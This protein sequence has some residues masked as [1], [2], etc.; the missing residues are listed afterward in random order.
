[1]KSVSV[2]A[3]GLW[4]DAKSGEF[5]PAAAREQ[6][7]R[8][9]EDRSTLVAAIND[10]FKELRSIRSAWRQA[11]PDKETYQ[12]A[13]RQWYQA[14]LEEGICSQGQVAFG[15]AQARK[16]PGDFIPS[17]GQ[18]IE[19][20]KPSPEMLGLPPLA[21]AH[22]EACRN[23]HPGMAGQGN[24]SHDAVWHAAKEC[25]FENLNRLAA[26]LSL[27]LFERNYAIAIRRI[28]AG[29]PL[30]PMPLAITQQVP[31]RSTPEV[32]REALAALRASRGAR[33]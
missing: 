11:W 21:K 22:R 2:I 33:P 24:W 32:A 31:S 9:S 23:A 30:Q 8:D 28:L 12:A 1:M 27:K 5:I 18:F 29:Q 17:P 7:P 3:R 15:M 6:H 14:F 10:L 13:K 4:S 26:D 16:Q 20:C 25:G 19:W